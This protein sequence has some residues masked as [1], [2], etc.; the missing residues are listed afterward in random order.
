MPTRLGREDMPPINR[1][2]RKTLHSFVDFAS[3]YFYNG[4]YL[5]GWH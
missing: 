2:L 3:T 5:G 4:P 1:H